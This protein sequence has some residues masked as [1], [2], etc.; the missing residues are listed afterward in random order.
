[1]KIIP[2]KIIQKIICFILIP[3]LFMSLIITNT[4]CTLK[5]RFSLRTSLADDSRPLVYTSIYPLY[6]FTKKIAG[7]NVTV[8]NITPAGI[9][10]HSFEPSTKLL[11]KLSKASLFIYNGA[12][13]E[14]YL[15][16]LQ[17]TLQGSSLLM[18]E[19]SQGINLIK[20]DQHGH[21]ES[22]LPTEN[23][24]KTE[25]EASLI[26]QDDEVAAIHMHEHEHEGIDPHTWLSPA[27]ARQIGQNILQ[28]LVQI[29]PD[30]QAA[31]EKNFQELQAQLTEL[32]LQYKEVLVAC[33][34]KDIIVT[35][36]AFGYLCREY[37]LNQIS[38]MGLHAEAEPTPGTLKEIIKLVN[39]KEIK[40]I[41]F[42]ALYSPKVAE[43]ISRETNTKILVLNPL[44]S[45]T[46]KALEDGQDYFSIM[47]ENLKN[48]KQALEYQP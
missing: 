24:S 3:P 40:Y 16:K 6:D 47:K 39:N 32:D 13:M 30:H 19:A 37:G 26:H 4:G 33:P 9:E 27:C 2:P 48:L 12:G 41:F 15:E 43:T 18:I 34:R 14:P 20:H 35:H 10:P 1:M 23:D 7:E 21:Q 44:G 42:E 17:K 38:V 11:A 25:Q 5:E 22:L 36:E 31:Y 8:I 29:D 28:A 45:L 46:E